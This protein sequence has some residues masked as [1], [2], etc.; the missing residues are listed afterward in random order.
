MSSII[1]NSMAPNRTET[2]HAALW[3]RLPGAWR[4]DVKMPLARS[5]QNQVQPG[6][7]R[8]TTTMHDEAD[9]QFITLIMPSQR[10]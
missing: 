4:G 1:T 10:C 7:R 8:K 2:N 6:T 5:G 3:I 9:L